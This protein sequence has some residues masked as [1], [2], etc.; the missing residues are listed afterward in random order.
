MNGRIIGFLVFLAIYIFLN[1]VSYLRLRQWYL[2]KQYWTKINLSVLFTE[3]FIIAGIA[4]M[5][6]RF[7]NP[8]EF[9]SAVQNWLIGAWFSMLVGK[10]IFGLVMLIDSI[11]ALPFLGVR[12]IQKKD[13][14]YN[15]TRRKFVK[16]ASLVIA[17]IPFIS[18]FTFIK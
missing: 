11:V 4:F 9:P 12:A 2:K 8:L 13:L 7:R 15:S 17:G 5:F 10:L 16:N 3:L 6:Y 1:V 14:S 18:F